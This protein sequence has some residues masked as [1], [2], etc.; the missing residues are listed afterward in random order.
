MLGL[1][2]SLEVKVLWV[3]NKTWKIIYS[4]YQKFSMTLPFDPEIYNLGCFGNTT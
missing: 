4:T 1:A 2:E 3:F